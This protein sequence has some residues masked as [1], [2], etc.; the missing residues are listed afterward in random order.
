AVL[1]QGC[2]AVPSGVTDTIQDVLSTRLDRL[3]TEQKRV[4]TT[5]AVIGKDVPLALLREVVGTPEDLLLKI[6][7]VLQKGEF[8]HETR[9]GLEAEYTFK[10]VLTR[11][12]AYDSLLPEAR[13][14]L[15]ARTVECIEALFPDPSPQIERLAY[16]AIQAED[17]DRAVTYLRQAGI[18]A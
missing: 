16:H 18:K 12:V 15:H 4:L 7:V 13:R 8:L 11:D 1:E 5:A 9:F 14:A 3:E 6:L 17:W 2:A 10:H